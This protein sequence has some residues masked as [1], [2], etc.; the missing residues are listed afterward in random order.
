MARPGIA[1]RLAGC[2]YR[3]NLAAALWPLLPVSWLFGLLVDLRRRLYRCALLP[4]QRLPVPVIVVGNLT[5]GGSG[6]TPLVLWLVGRLREQGWRPGIISRGYGGAAHKVRPVLA[7]SPASLVGDEPLLLAR[8]SGVPVFVGRDRPAAGRALLAA[9]PECDVIVSDDGLQ[10][11][12]LQRTFEAGRLRSAR[13]RQ[14]LSAAGRP[15]A[16]ALAASGRDRRGGLERIAGGAG[17]D[18]RPA[19]AAVRHATG[20]TAFRRR[21]RRRALL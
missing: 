20:R 15:L 3:R 21:E 19:P 12:R 18:S 10:H 16:R 1:Q 14:R 13:R 5:V 6:K 17:R 11:Y 2:W 7:S 8:R 9:H 4:S